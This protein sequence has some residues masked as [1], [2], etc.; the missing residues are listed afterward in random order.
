MFCVFFTCGSGI[1]NSSYDQDFL[2]TETLNFGVVLL[3]LRGGDVGGGNRWSGASH[4]SVPALGSLS[5]RPDRCSTILVRTP[6]LC[7]S[8]ESKPIKYQVIIESTTVY[9]SM[10]YQKGTRAVK[11]I[12]YFIQG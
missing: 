7:T 8:Y 4:R 2:V 1:S 11:P 12:V 6:V 5:V 10:M 9:T 3:F